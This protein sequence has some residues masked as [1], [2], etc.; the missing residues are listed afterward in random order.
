MNRAVEKKYALVTGGASGMGLAIV[1]R[2]AAEGHHVFMVDRDGATAAR[3]ASRLVSAGF[4][5]EAKVLDL[6]DESASRQMIAQMP[7]L[8]V[9]VNNAGIFDERG[10]FDVSSADFQR[11]F[12]VN[13]LAVATLTQ[14]VAKKMLPG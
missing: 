5:V 9:L 2:M 10:F 13:M 6:M 12:A 1:E 7:A 8:Q 4:S 14:E 11:M 3:E